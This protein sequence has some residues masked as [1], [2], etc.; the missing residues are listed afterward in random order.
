MNDLENI[1]DLNNLQID[2]LSDSDF[3]H[4]QWLNLQHYHRDHKLD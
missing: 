4:I 1:V 2:H 3:D